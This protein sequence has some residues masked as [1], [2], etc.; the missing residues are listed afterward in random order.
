MQY[1][2]ATVNIDEQ[3]KEILQTKKVLIVDD[4]EL[5]AEILE[6]ALASFFEN[7]M[8]AYNGEHALSL[9]EE[10]SFDLII[11][12]LDMPQINGIELACAIKEKRDEVHILVSSSHDNKENLFEL[13]N[14]GIDG[15]LKKPTYLPELY[16]VLH[17]TFANKDL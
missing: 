10:N 13:I 14:I 12:D 6:E 8:V 4:D 3:L 5:Y 15:F 1:E 7:T 9:I 11:T 17:K 16:R 2:E